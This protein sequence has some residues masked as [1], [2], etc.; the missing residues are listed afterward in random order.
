LLQRELKSAIPNLFS[1]AIGNNRLQHIFLPSFESTYL[2]HFRYY[3]IMENVMAK[4][5][6]NNYLT[7]A[8]YKPELRLNRDIKDILIRNL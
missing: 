4:E 3:I 6:S 7:L 2:L 5:L 8:N 1:P